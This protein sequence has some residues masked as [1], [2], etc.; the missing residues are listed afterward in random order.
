MLSAF[1]EK[2]SAVAQEQYDKFHFHSEN[3]KPL[4]D[5]IKVY[6]AGLDLKF[7]GV[8]TAWS[9]VFVSWCIKQAGATSSEFRFSARHSDFVF[10]AISNADARRGLFQALPITECAPSVG[11]IIHNNREGKSFDYGFAAANRKY[12]SHSAIVVDTGRDGTGRFATTI[13]GNESDS[14]RRKRVILNEDGFIAQ[15]K[16]NPY[17]CVIQTLK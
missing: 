14:V 11:D 12:E 3:D 17:I 13:G 7:P 8:G 10:W 5:Q 1:E 2:V 9:A 15:R 6:W 4:A 16:A